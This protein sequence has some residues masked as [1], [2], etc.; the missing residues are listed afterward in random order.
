M[1]FESLDNYLA[2]D[3]YLPEDWYLVYDGKRTVNTK[4]VV[5]GELPFATINAFPENALLTFQTQI[6]SQ[7]RAADSCCLA[8]F[9]GT[10][11]DPDVT[12]AQHK[13]L[14]NG[15]TSWGIPFLTRA[16]QVYGCTGLWT[17]QAQ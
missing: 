2:N 6:V 16:W 15:V 3:F 7:N 12:N 10:E 1:S 11:C 17:G 4:C 8:L 9:E 13:F 14:C 5:V